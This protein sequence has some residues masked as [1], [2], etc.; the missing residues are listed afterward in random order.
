MDLNK[1]KITATLV[2]PVR[3][4]NGKRKVLFAE[5]VRKIGIGRLNGFGGSLNERETIRDCATRELRKESGLVAMNQD[6]EFVG[7]MT[8][9]NKRKDESIFVVRVFVFIARKW[10][11][12]LKVKTDEMVN[13]KW[14]KTCRLPLKKMM[15]ADPFWVPLVLRGKKIK[16]EAWYGPEQK[17]MLRLPEIKMVEYLSDID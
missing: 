11:G 14:Y 17:T 10:R 2:F 15:P 9:H 4:E 3:E 6:L 13:P 16:G 7:V 1:N 8:I 5:K 12:K